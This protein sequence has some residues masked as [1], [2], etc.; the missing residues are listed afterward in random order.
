MTTASESE[1]LKSSFI[2]VLSGQIDTAE[3]CSGSNLYCKYS[4]VYGSDWTQVSG[5]REGLSSLCQ[6]NAHQNHLVFDL[7]ITATF[8]STNPFGWPRIVISCYGNDIF[9]NDVIRGYGATHIPTV[10]GR[11]KRK[12]AIY[13][14]EASTMLQKL[15]GWITGRRAEFTDPRIVASG[16]GRRVTRVRS[17]GFVNVTMDV[18][19]KDM[20][21]LGFDLAFRPPNSDVHQ[22]DSNGSALRENDT[23]DKTREESSDK[24]S[25]LPTVDATQGPAHSAAPVKPRRKKAPAKPKPMS[26]S[27]LPSPDTSETYR[28]VPKQT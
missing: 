14:P 27:K 12:I 26:E 20:Q 8:R 24:T 23:V 22:T 15:I 9:G 21:K 13:V 10:P 11:T 6:K 28:T 17:K 3:V 25:N 1:Y 16:S 2:I 19:I 7:P 5:V 4:Y 18:M